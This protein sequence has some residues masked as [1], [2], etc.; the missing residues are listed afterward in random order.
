[1][2]KVSSREELKEYCL[3]RLGFPVISINCSDEQLEDRMDDALQFFTQYHYDA[4]EKIYAKHEV[5]QEDID[6]RYLTVNDSVIAITRMFPLSST[7]TK[8]Y[9]WD[10]QYQLRLHELWDFTSIN[11]LNYV[12]TMQ[13]L[14]NLELLFTGEVPIRYQ[15]H[16]NKVYL[17]LAWGTTE[18]PLGATVILEGYAI[19]DPDVYHNVYNDMWL[20]EYCTELFRR[21]FGTNLFKHKDMELP[22]GV[23]LN[24]GEILMEANRNIEKLEQQIQDRFEGVLEFVIG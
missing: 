16:T 18:L 11:M 13:H 19:I 21:Q 5:T 4:V 20:K 15:R 1:M 3:R 12:V 23:R 24:G 7:W 17:D 9:M 6:N 10:I 22:G 14:R 8:S 2:A